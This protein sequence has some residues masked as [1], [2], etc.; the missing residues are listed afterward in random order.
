MRV[1][2]IISVAPWLMGASS[3]P[4]RKVEGHK[5]YCGGETTNIEVEAY[6]SRLKDTLAEGGSGARFKQFVADRFSITD[7]RGRWLSF[8]LGDFNSITPGRITRA[9]WGE[10]AKRGASGLQN[11]GWR[12]CFLDHGKVWFE[13]DEKAGFKLTSVA[14]N[15]PWVP[16]K[17][18]QTR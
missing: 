16:A 14:K 12:G 18:R 11:A 4:A 13:A 8:R 5:I 6:F 15:M 2:A 10:I 3:L 1:L 7:A 9:E 17:Q